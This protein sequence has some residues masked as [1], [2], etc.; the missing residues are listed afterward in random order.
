MA[1]E[2]LNRRKFP[3]AKFPCL[4]KIL[5]EGRAE[6]SIL[7]H[8]ENISIGGVCVIIK[9]QLEIFSPLKV[10]ID[11]IDGDSVISCRGKAVWV[12]RRKALE[13]VKPLFYDTGIEFV[14]L[15][16]ADRVRIQKTVDF[17]VKNGH[18]AAYR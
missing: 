8:T 10:E 3:R 1:W 17:L 11:L 6:E 5:K 12:V 16:D 2:G 4:V 9:R 13:D 14:D 15:S 18:E 7:T